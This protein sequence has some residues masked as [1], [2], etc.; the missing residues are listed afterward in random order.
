MRIRW[1]DKDNLN[2]KLQQL[3]QLDAQKVS[4]RAL[5]RMFNRA[6]DE[7]FTPIDTGELRISRNTEMPSGNDLGRFGYIKEYAP[8]VEYGHRT[9]NGGYVPGQR[10]LQSNVEVE[11]PIFIQEVDEF[12][13]R[14]MKK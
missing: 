11:R 2:G 3:S 13:K 4:G 6:A 9:V 10:Y 8:H 14:S 1:K 12:I 5:K 7:P